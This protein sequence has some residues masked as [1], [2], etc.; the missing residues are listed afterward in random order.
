MNKTS[1]LGEVYGNQYCVLLKVPVFTRIPN[2]PQKS[3]LSLLLLFHLRQGDL[4]EIVFFE[5][6]FNMLTG[7]RNTQV[8]NES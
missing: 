3:L 1:L 6:L 5:I 2:L 4:C 7:L 8:C